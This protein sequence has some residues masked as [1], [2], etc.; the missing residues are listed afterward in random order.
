ML[1]CFH[2][3][4]ASLLGDNNDSNNNVND[5]NDD[6]DNSNS[7]TELVMHASDSILSKHT[8]VGDNARFFCNK[9]LII[10]LLKVNTH[11]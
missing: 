4:F 1:L 8:C 5:N 9:M 7:K 11:I 10:E 2:W 3:R 6:D